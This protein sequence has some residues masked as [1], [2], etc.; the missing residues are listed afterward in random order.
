MILLKISKL[1][2]LTSVAMAEK[3]HGLEQAAAIE[4]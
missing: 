2:R 1:L 3:I 4:K